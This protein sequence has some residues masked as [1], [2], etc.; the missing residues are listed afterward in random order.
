VVITTPLLE[1]T[2]GVQKMSKS[3][4]NYIGINE[5]AKEMFG[6]IMSVSDVLMWRYYE[7][8][9][10]ISLK[11][12][13]DMKDNMHPRDAKVKLAK[14]II[15]TYHD[16]KSADIAEKEFDN[17][18]RKG[19]IPEDR[20]VTS[21]PHMEGKIWVCELLKRMSLTVSNTEA[22]RMIEQG[23][24]TIDGKKISD[25]NA[26]IETRD[27]LIVQVGKRRVGELRKKPHP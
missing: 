10:D 9:T 19:Q 3:Y 15:A 6:K 14:E 1:G 5:P 12:I 16:K 4:G 2:D 11:E 21:E 23:A 25:V 8:L 26:Q 7:L 13:G 20:I 18:F 22:R 17:V 27:G 24:V